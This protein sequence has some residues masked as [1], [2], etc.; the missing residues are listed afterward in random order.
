MSHENAG[1]DEQS[2]SCPCFQ[3]TVVKGTA[4]SM[5]DPQ[6]PTEIAESS[7]PL[8]QDSW[9]RLRTIID[10][11]AD[12][13]VIVDKGGAIRFANPAA[14]RLFNRSANELIGTAFGSPLLAGETTEMEIV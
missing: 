6:P 3:S 14:E 9:D 12:G 7:E 10:S 2:R 4:D 5:S 11:L 8:G 13:I 1:P